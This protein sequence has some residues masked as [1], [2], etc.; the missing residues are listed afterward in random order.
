MRVTKIAFVDGVFNMVP[1][2]LENK[3]EGLE[4]KRRIV[5]IRSTA[6]DRLESRKTEDIHCYSDYSERPPTNVGVKNFQG[7]K[8]YYYY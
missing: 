7:A 3:L 4:T 8:C 6:L 2:V 5:T 1:K